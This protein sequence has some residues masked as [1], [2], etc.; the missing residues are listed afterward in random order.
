VWGSNQYGQL[1]DGGLS[2]LCHAPKMNVSLRKEWVVDATAGDMHT[3]AVTEAGKY[4]FS[5]YVVC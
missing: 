5:F 3:I 4:I 1:G 2:K